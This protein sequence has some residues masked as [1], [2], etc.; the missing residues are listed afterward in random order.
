VRDKLCTYVVNVVAHGVQLAKE[1]WSL[2]AWIVGIRKVL[3]FTEDVLILTEKRGEERR[4]TTALK[5]SH[6]GKVQQRS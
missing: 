1:D 4:A 2:I 6:V 5:S 3:A